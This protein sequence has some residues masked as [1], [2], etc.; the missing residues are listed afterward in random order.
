MSDTQAAS[1][2]LQTY[3]QTV[4]ATPDIQLPAEVDKESDSTVVEDLPKH[5]ALARTNANFYIT[6][7]NKT[8]VDTVA[9]VIGFANLWNAEYARLQDLA[10]K[11]DEGNNKETFKQGVAN[12]ISKS[13]DAENNTQPALDA[14]NNFL[15]KIETDQRNLTTD[16]QHV[17]VALDGQSGQIAQLKK[18]IDADNDAINKDLAIIAGGATAD[19][20]G[21]LMIAVGLL[22]EIETAGAST[23]LVVGGLALVAGGTTAMGI[24]GKNLS[25]TKSDLSAATKQLK[26][27]E[28]VNLSTKQCS[29]TVVNLVSAISQGVNA[30]TS[31]QK[32]WSALQSDFNQV[33]SQLDMANPD[34]GSWLSDILT[35]ANTDWQDTLTLAK[36]LQQYGTL[37]AKTEDHTQ[38]EAA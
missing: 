14:L 10:S 33:I 34:L 11:I 3:T 28:L 8:L 22:A 23:A 9:E 18:Q 15:P 12:L 21:G 38:Q 37:P 25:D 29:N 27:D 32:G 6:D 2:M 24:A 16:E 13:Q 1:I 35:A 36:S 30:V 19:V 31:L 7:V 26:I 20:V 17:S 5:Q 4:L